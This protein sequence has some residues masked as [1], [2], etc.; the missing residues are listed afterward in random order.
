MT[1][2]CAALLCKISQSVSAIFQASANRSDPAC[3][4]PL[5]MEQW[6]QKWVLNFGF[7]FQIFQTFHTNIQRPT[8]MFEANVSAH[9][10]FL[11]LIAFDHNPAATHQKTIPNSL[12]HAL[13]KH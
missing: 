10:P 5:R 7:L 2:P 1:I 6:F 13:Y 12:Y 11:L 3:Y 9:T 4:A 8:H